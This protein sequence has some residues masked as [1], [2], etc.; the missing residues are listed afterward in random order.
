MRG[1]LSSLSAV[2]FK[3]A[4]LGFLLLFRLLSALPAEV[5]CPALFG[6]HMVLQ[7]DRAVPIWGDAAVGEKVTVEFGGQNKTT[8]ADDAGH[9][10]VV[11]DSLSA[12]DTPRVL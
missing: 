11:L 4:L 5:R 1:E 2:N 10:K 8:M 7:R 3:S 6:D 12:S 9:W